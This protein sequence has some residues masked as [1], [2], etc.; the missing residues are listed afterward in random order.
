MVKRMKSEFGEGIGG[1]VSSTDDPNNPSFDPSQHKSETDKKI[2][3]LLEP[4]TIDRLTECVKD[5]LLNVYGQVPL[6]K[7]QHMRVW[8]IYKKH[9]EPAPPTP[10]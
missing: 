8:K 7:K 6:S 3:F 10:S 4:H 2:R 1:P 9:T 5:F